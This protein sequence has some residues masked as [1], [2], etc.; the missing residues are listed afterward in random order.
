MDS[1]F[2]KSGWLKSGVLCAVT[3]LALIAGSSLVRAQGVGVGVGVAVPCVAY[4]G[5]VG[6]YN[7]GCGYWTGSAWDPLWFGFGHGGYGHGHWDSRDHGNHGSH[8]HRHSH[9]AH[10]KGH[11]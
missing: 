8:G 1:F 10:A 4:A 9:P 5:P 6:F 7:P 11:R 2:D 3:G